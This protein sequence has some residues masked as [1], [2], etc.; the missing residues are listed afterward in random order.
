MKMNKLLAV[1][2]T[3]LFLAPFFAARAET[4]PAF[5]VDEGAVLKGMDRSWRQGYTAA[6]SGNKWTLVLPVQS[7][8]AAGSLKA[9]LVVKD[10]RTTPFKLQAMTVDARQEELN[11]GNWA[12]RFVLALLPDQKNADYPC[13]IRIT[14]KDRKGNALSTEIPYTVKIRGCKENLEKPRITIA[15]V[16]AELSVGE[17]GTV[18]VTLA[19]P[20]AAANIEDL[21]LRISDASGH[22]LPRESDTLKIGSLPVGESVTVSYPVTVLEKAAVTPHVLKLELSWTAAGQAA[23]YTANNTVAVRQE[24][25]LE[26]GGLRMAPAVT[27]GDSLNL[28]LPIMNMGKADVVNVLATVTLP[29]VTERQ[30]VLVGTI[31]PGETK[32]AQLVLSPAKDVSGEFA[33][34]LTVECTDQDGNPASFSL[35]VNLKVEKPKPKE[36]AQR[37]AAGETAAKEKP[38]VLTW[39]LAGGCGLLLMMLLAQGI[40]MRRK[41]HL[42]EEEKL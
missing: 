20:C 31:Q 36:T 39:A 26:Q 16:Q 1:L 29:G 9:E 25:R 10:E 4:A 21:E 30:S 7:E 33:G 11:K 3:A 14:G 12:V 22:I 5:T 40:V 35:P 32:Q 13:V 23:S 42:L 34:S 8:L 27:A 18:R 15:D 2:L 19:N 6:V 41:L 37:G 17:E 24:I 28:T 38:G